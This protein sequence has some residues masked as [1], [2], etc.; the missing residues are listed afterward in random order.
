MTFKRPVFFRFFLLFSLFLLLFSCKKKPQGDETVSGVDSTLTEKPE[1]KPKKELMSYTTIVFPKDKKGKDSAMAVFLKTYSKEE[2]YLILALNRLDQ[3]N[4]WRAD[5]LI[6]PKS[7]KEDFIKYTP[8]PLEVKAIEA[9]DKMAIFSYSI[10]AYGLYEKGKLIKWGPSSMGK[11]ETPTKKGL[12]FTNWKKEVA[13][14]T[15]NSEWKLRWNFNIHNTMGIGWHQYDLPGFHASHSCLRLLEEDAY[16]MYSWAE[17]WQLTNKGQTVKAKGTPVL[18]Y[19]DSDFKSKPWIA[20][21]SDPA[22]NEISEE[23]LSKELS[24]L[25]EEILK[26]QENTKKVKSE[27][28]AS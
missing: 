2:Q 4:R 23:E 22:A 16:W 24:P 15:S 28:L 18:V 6:I 1:E 5:T 3:K 19:G 13:I 14:S 26:E 21:S 17:T 9:V 7:A 27:K 12:M 20:L 25:V 8:F 10:H 11:K